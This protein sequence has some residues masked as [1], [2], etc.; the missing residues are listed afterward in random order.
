MVAGNSNT[1]PLTFIGIF[2][3]ISTI[4]GTIG[5]EMGEAFG[6]THAVALF[7]LAVILMLIVLVVNSISNLTISRLSKRMH[8]ELKHNTRFSKKETRILKWILLIVASAVILDYLA[9][10]IGLVIAISIAAIVTGIW[11]MIKIL[12]RRSLQAIAFTIISFA[13]AIVV[14]FICYILYD[15]VSKGAPVATVKF[16][17]SMPSGNGKSGG[18]YSAI[19]GTL[20]L[21][22]GALIVAVPI[23]ICAAIYLNE[24]SRENLL[25]K[26]IRIG[27]DNLNG[28]PSIIFGLFGYTLFVM[29]F[30]FGYSLI[31]GQLT[32]GFMI[33]PMIIRT[34]EESLKT[35]PQSLR[36]ASLALGAT[37]WQTI[38]KVV[39]PASTPGTLTGIILGIGRA[40]GETAPILFTACAF[41]RFLAGSLTDPVMALP[42]QIYMLSTT[43][44]DAISQA[45]G[46]AYVLLILVLLMYGIA[47]VSRYY[48][49][50]KFKM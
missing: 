45:Y 11:I 15:I 20:E 16:I 36:E 6:L 41:S 50:N 48:Y 10:N 42:Y 14:F 46:T 13:A 25:K 26:I 37:K 28:L 21:V 12:P 23:G 1:I 35:V 8:G 39:L 38:T 33:L 49:R 22:A 4:T 7:G 24:Y 31:A 30:G 47:I 43:Y 2:W 3:P 5:L 32:L 17:F 29:Q 18:I 44:P 40:A 34:T 27:V 9:V 19:I